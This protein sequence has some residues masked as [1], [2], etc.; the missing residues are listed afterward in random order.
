MA[1]PIVP[2]R[3]GCQ[4]YELCGPDGAP[5]VLLL[6]GAFT[7]SWQY[8]LLRDRLA[9][10]LRVIT[11][12][13]RGDGQSLNQLWD[14]TP[15][16]IAEDMGVLLDHLGAHGCHVIAISL[17]VFVLAEMMHRGFP[18]AGRTILVSAPALRGRLKLP[19]T[20]SATFREL[21]GKR[22]PRIQQLALAAVSLFVSPRFMEE[23]PERYRD[24]MER[25]LAVSGTEVWAGLQQFGGMF[26]YDW[27]RPRILE[28][29][30]RG[31][32]LVLV[33]DRD[34]LAPLANVREHPLFREGP[35]LVFREA[36]HRFF[37]EDAGPFGEIAHR[38]LLEGRLPDPLPVRGLV[39]RLEECP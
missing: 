18:A 16:Q 12:D 23:Q 15:A 11:V 1:M 36:G 17:G 37:Y 19:L 9:S 4:F 7:G 31:A 22:V 33:G 26:G 35:T 14:V 28:R 5:F 8:D 24:M 32:R 21:E 39:Q 29:L 6:R 27:G 3:K 38:F 25:T 10:D 13:Y 34:L 30:P 2:T 20:P